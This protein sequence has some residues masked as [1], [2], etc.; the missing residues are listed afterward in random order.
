M[1]QET[2]FKQPVVMPAHLKNHL[3]AG[4]ALKDKHSI[5]IN[6]ELWFKVCRKE[7]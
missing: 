5:K 2:S 6:N 7:A 4:F 3:K 1:T